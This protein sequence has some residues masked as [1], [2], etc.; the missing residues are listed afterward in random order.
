MVNGDKSFE[1]I[2]LCLYTYCDATAVHMFNLQE[3]LYNMFY[4]HL[5]MHGD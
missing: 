2:C 5:M 1:V 4:T 3:M